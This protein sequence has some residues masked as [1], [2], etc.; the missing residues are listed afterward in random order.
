MS[1]EG[2]T[3]IAKI[4]E[5]VGVSNEGWEEAARNALKEASKTLDNITGVEVT[6]YT[7]NV[8]DGNILQYKAAVKIA[9]GLTGR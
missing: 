7:A 6:N 1:E 9:F 8:K 4:I 5:V 3:N 2:V